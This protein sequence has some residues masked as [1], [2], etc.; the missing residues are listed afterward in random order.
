MINFFDII[1]SY[2]NRSCCLDRLNEQEED[3][4]QKFQEL[5]TFL[6]STAQAA[7][8]ATKKAPV[9]GSKGNVSYE[10]FDL[11]RGQFFLGAKSGLP[12]G[13]INFTEDGRLIKPT[14]PKQQKAVATALVGA[15]GQDAAAL[16]P[17]AVEGPT[18]AKVKTKKGYSDA[19]KKRIEK[20]S[21]RVVEE[22][23]QQISTLFD[24]LN[25]AGQ[26][27]GICSLRLSHHKKNLRA[28]SKKKDSK[29]NPTELARK[30]LQATRSIN[31]GNFC[32]AVGIIESDSNLRSYVSSEKEL[33][34]QLQ[35]SYQLAIFKQLR[36]PK[37]FNGET[38]KFALFSNCLD[39]EKRDEKCDAYQDKNVILQDVKATIENLGKAVEL[40]SKDP[41]QITE[42]EKKELTELIEFTTDGFALI[43]GSGSYIAI[44]DRFE[45]FQDLAIAA[46]SLIDVKFIVHDAGNFKSGNQNNLMGTIKEYMHKLAGLA[47]LYENSPDNEEKQK[48]IDQALKSILKDI[49]GLCR[50]LKETK[51]FVKGFNSGESSI[52]AESLGAFRQISDGLRTMSEC[53]D[54]TPNLYYE[55]ALAKERIEEM[56]NPLVV[57]TG[58][59]TKNGTRRDLVYA[60]NDEES[61]ITS[62]MEAHGIDRKTA[63]SYVQVKTMREILNDSDEMRRALAGTKVLSSPDG[64]FNEDRQVYVIPEGIKNYLR[65][66]GAV[67]GSGVESSTLESI[68]NPKTKQERNWIDQTTKSLGLPPEVSQESLNLLREHHQELE[69][70]KARIEKIGIK[71]VGNTTDSSHQAY[72]EKIEGMYAE[73]NHP[74]RMA[75]EALRQAIDSRNPQAI[76]KYKKT[77]AEAMNVQQTRAFFEKGI[78]DSASQSEKAAVAIL[79]TMPATTNEKML[80]TVHYPRVGSR[81]ARRISFDHNEACTRLWRGFLEGSPGHSVSLGELSSEG[82]YNLSIADDSGKS[83]KTYY[84]GRSA[85]VHANKAL[86]ADVTRER[87][88][89]KMQDMQPNEQQSE[90]ISINR[91]KKDTLTILKETLILQSKLFKKLFML[92]S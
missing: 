75:S 81:A 17:A 6:Q 19:A 2:N 40:M 47:V 4:T 13:H 11:G 89:L 65:D 64:E 33:K 48:E 44:K 52:P 85:E 26:R 12:G 68:A 49:K 45:Q 80:T 28:L 88:P 9:R 69:K 22:A 78:S 35:F 92:N 83:L 27:Q 10:A 82:R 16:T 76:E 91:N 20:V 8:G 71:K 3:Y 24:R 90:S 54:L 23:Q 46:E 34:E 57:Q 37:N 29:G 66:D 70:V 42:A 5:Q 60:Y 31:I 61:A 14:A 73:A 62:L 59:I 18:R 32:D 63:K 86:I 43:K 87:E 21:N 39:P 25:D 84:A 74:V 53:K 67:L 72:L 77:L 58:A 15:P 38:A 51:D 50:Y 55:L 30:A 56:G 41:S 79:A 1:E 7:K 36:N